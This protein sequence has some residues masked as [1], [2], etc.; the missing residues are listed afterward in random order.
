MLNPDDIVFLKHSATDPDLLGESDAMEDQ[1]SDD[2]S[3]D[4]HAN[5]L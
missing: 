3:S 2:Q 4:P 5:C 1:I